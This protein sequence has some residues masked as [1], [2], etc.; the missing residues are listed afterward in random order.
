M[1]RRLMQTWD[2]RKPQIASDKGIVAAQHFE[3]AAA[4][5]RVLDRGGNAMDAAVVTALVLSVVEPWL[6]GVGGGGLLLWAAADGL[7]V[8]TLDFN[9]RASRNIS[10][11][12]YPL[13]GG[14]D[15]NW[16]DWPTV[17]GDRNLIGYSSISVPGAV[18]GLSAALEKYGTLSWAD[19]LQPAIDLAERGML[20]DWFTSLCIAIDMQ[21][22]A[23]FPDTAALFLDDGGKP[24]RQL[25]PEAETYLPMPAKARMLRR[26]AEA[27]ARDFYEGEIAAMLVADLK[28]GGS[29]IDAADL[30]GYAPRWASPAVAGYRGYE[31]N[32]V[33]GLCGGPS[34]LATLSWLEG[35][36]ASGDVF[37]PHA[38]KAY[39]RAIRRSYEY[40][41]NA[42][43]HAGRREGDCTSHISVVDGAGNMASLTNTVLSR[44]GSKVLLPQTGILMNNGM[45]WFDPRPDVPNA[46]APCAQPLANMAPAIVRKA[47]RPWLA[48]GAAGG[49]QIFPA[50]TQLI[51]YV[52]DGGMS[53][54][55]AFHAP[56]LD[57]S[58][59]TIVID[60]TAAANV[61][62]AVSE[63][64]PVRLTSNTL[65]PVNFAIPS[66][67]MHDAEN[68]RRYG[69]VHPVNPWTHAAAE[70]GRDG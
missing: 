45:M 15:G 30:A 2:I 52:I 7:A 62:A 14:R 59:P 27:G 63:E 16:F 32:T 34:L 35:E 69:M 22:I 21:G 40:R 66:A 24:R 43:G 1:E 50:L 19:A 3:A 29:V 18:A 36:S 41:L 64:Y 47:G 46:I 53:L 39:A 37:G 25:R 60:R 26:L 11:A 44:F 70:G 56:R 10:R 8:D 65:H 33:G 23:Q 12:D 57:G 54:E 31:V 9:V 42:M 4:G 48:I 51:S 6:S 49:R 55:A 68:G 38:A 67:V 61:A 5:A 13:T 17:E 20:V 28:A 58:T